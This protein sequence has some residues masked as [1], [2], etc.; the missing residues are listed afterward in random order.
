[1]RG[2]NGGASGVAKNVPM[3]AAVCGEGGG[4]PR[5]LGKY[6][7]YYSYVSRRTT[8]H[9]RQERLGISGPERHRFMPALALFHE[10]YSN[11]LLKKKLR[12]NTAAH[13]DLFWYHFQM[14]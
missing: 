13:Q 8:H 2:D 4:A 7:L 10:R 12:K 3:C 1:M 5:S 6:T 9:P 11:W 14:G